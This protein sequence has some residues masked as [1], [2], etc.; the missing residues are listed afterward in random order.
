VTDTG[1]ENLLQEERL[2]PPSDEFAAQANA[3]PELYTEA[4]EDFVA[5]WRKN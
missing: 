4:S 3:G 1:I 2:F 5:Y